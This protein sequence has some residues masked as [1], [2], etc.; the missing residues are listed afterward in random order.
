MYKGS[1]HA[2]N[3]ENLDVCI[4]SYCLFELIVVPAIGQTDKCVL[5]FGVRPQYKILTNLPR[6]IRSACILAFNLH[7]PYIPRQSGTKYP[8]VAVPLTIEGD[9]PPPPPGPL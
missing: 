8:V 7:N 1:I 4:S 5:F 6:N 3:V 2:P 9:L